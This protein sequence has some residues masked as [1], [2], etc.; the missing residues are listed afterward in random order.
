LLQEKK[1]AALET[2]YGVEPGT[3]WLKNGYNSGGY[4]WCCSNWMTK[5][6]AV[7]VS[8]T[9]RRDTSRCSV[10]QTLTCAY[11]KTTHKTDGMT[12]F[13]CQQCGSPLPDTH[14]LQAFLEFDT[15]WCPPLP[16]IEKLASMFSDHEFELKYYEGGIG[17]CGHVRWA[18][19]L[20]TLHEM[21]D[22]D[23]PRGG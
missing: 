6:N 22:Y 16:V 2:E 11:C 5:W 12:V 20:K 4:D 8:I 10:D 18:G 1:L 3:P 21:D 7:H 17:F 15:A 19:G 14:P 9:T 13:I 23:G